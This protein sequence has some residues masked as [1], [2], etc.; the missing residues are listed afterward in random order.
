[1]EHIEWW[2]LKCRILAR[3]TEGRWQPVDLYR[4][5]QSDFGN[6]WRCQL[7]EECYQY[8]L[9]ED[10]CV[11]HNSACTLWSIGDSDWM[12]RLSM[13][14]DVTD[15]RRSRKSFCQYRFGA[16]LCA[17]FGLDVLRL[18]VGNCSELI[19]TLGEILW[20]CG[21]ASESFDFCP[22]KCKY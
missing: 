3:E 7:W 21:C 11:W 10:G 15:T 1:M 17:W 19:N 8:N 22:I 6:F 16:M 20:R 4:G 5:R 9:L 13:T 2:T 14:Q 12:H 18:C